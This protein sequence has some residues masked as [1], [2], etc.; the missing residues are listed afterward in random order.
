MIILLPSSLSNDVQYSQRVISN[1]SIF[2][3]VGIRIF[4]LLS[5]LRFLCEPS[6]EDHLQRKEGGD[7]DWGQVRVIIFLCPRQRTLDKPPDWSHI[8]I[9]LIIRPKDQCEWAIP[10]ILDGQTMT[11]AILARESNL[12][13]VFMDGWM[14][15]VTSFLCLLGRSSVRSGANT[16]GFHP[17]SSRVCWAFVW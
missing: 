5:R 4:I 3:F 14:P 9:L 8:F 15:W 13:V 6:T 16:G 10:G 2:Q 17:L 1:N 12:R 7:V 11:E